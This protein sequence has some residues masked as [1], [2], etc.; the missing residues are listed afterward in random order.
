MN[1]NTYSTHDPFPG[2]NDPTSSDAGILQEFC[3]TLLG[4]GSTSDDL[5]EFAGNDGLTSAVEQNLELVDHVSGVLRCVLIL[6][7]RHVIP[8]ITRS[9]QTY[10]HGISSRRL[11]TGMAFSKCLS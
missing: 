7:V 2:P 8:S 4:S 10:V 1:N 3:L 6:I 9:R 5:D 11:L